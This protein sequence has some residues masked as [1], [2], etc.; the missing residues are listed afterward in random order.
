[1]RPGAAR[2]FPTTTQQHRLQ[3]DATC[4]WCRPA[5]HHQSDPLINIVVEPVTHFSFQTLH[6]HAPTL[7]LPPQWSGWMSWL[8]EQCYKL[9][10]EPPQ[11]LSPSGSD[12]SYWTSN[13][14]WVLSNDCPFLLVPGMMMCGVL[15]APGRPGGGGGGARITGGAGWWWRAGP[16]H[17]TTRTQLVI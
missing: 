16:L 17:P 12:Q 11:F 14:R 4:G 13:E 15:G 1:V 5:H 10:W 3:C 7:K 2:K 9:N 8:L 6:P